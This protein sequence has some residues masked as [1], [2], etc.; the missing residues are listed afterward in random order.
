[1]NLFGG[2]EGPD[3]NGC[4]EPFSFV[5]F[6]GT[7]SFRG[8]GGYTSIEARRAG[9]LLIDPA[10]ARCRQRARA[11]TSARRDSRLNTS[12][13]A[14]S[15]Q[16]G[17]VTSF[18]LQ[19]KR[20]TSWAR[21][22]ALRQERRGEVRILRWATTVVGGDNALILSGPGVR[23]PFAFVEAPKPFSGSAVLDASAAPDQQWTGS[24][25]AWM[26]GLGKAGLAGPGYALS[27]C[28]RTGD[29]PGCDPEA[30]VRR[31]L[32]MLQG[33]GS[34]SQLFAEARLSWSRY[35]RNSASSAGSTP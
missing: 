2:R 12:L 5:A 10:A 26:P 7:I 31:E 6:K 28:R 29:E 22:A 15:R 21:L 33:S 8:E 16:G 24:L 9:G 25:A 30:P 19:R 23:P 1:V 11:S 34:Q 32:S 18:W 14:I 17:A 13:Q 3:R 27:F 20:G 35:L 4:E